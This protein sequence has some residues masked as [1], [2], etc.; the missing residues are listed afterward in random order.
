[1]VEHQFKFPFSFIYAWAL[2]FCF[3]TS[4]IHKT[5]FYDICENWTTTPENN[6]GGTRDRKPIKG[7]EVIGCKKYV[8]VYIYDK[9]VKKE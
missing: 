5:C 4:C 7:L 2:L 1:M 3:K 9:A 6:E 8:Y